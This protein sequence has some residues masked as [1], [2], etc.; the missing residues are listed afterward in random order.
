MELF[1]QVCEIAATTAETLILLEFI[2]KLLGCR[3]EG[4]GRIFSFAASFIIINGYMVFAGIISPEYSA[5]S[6]II[7]LGLYVLYAL[8]T[9]KCSIIYRIITPALCITAII[10]INT[11]VYSAVSLAFNIESGSLIVE[12]SAF[13]AVSLFIT[14]FAFFL[15]TRM[16]LKIVKPH[17]VTLSMRELASVSVTFLATAVLSAFWV[18]LEYASELTDISRFTAAFLV[19]IVAINAVNFILLSIIARKNNE[20]MQQTLMQ[21][22]FEEQKKMY[23]SVTAVY[24]D[25]QLL[26]HDL[27][28]ELLCVQNY[29]ELNQTKKAVQYIE[30]LTNTKLSAFHEYVKTGSVLLDAMINI[31]LNYAREHGIDVCC[32]IGINLEGYDENGIMILFSNAMDNAVEAALALPQPKRKIILAMENKQNYL[33]I[34]IANS[35]GSSVLKNNAGLS[36]TKKNKKMHGLGT[37]SMKNII[38]QYDGMIDYYEKK[39]MFVV[40]MMVKKEA[41]K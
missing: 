5:M 26:Q 31:K 9:A 10:L 4:A 38:E 7:V 30:N 2:S 29:I 11:L 14:K 22:Q 24:H 40:S 15:I 21:V 19:C 13:R 34:T 36:T 20:A 17:T 18:E 12:H 23:D 37:R 39:E 41:T 1:Y 25:L 6:D 27:K 16:V 3:F 32:N 35:I 28:N 33:C 8:F